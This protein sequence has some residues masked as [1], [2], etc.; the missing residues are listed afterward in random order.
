MWLRQGATDP[1]GIWEACCKK[2]AKK[3]KKI[4]FFCTSWTGKQANIH[5]MLPPPCFTV[6]M[7]RSERWAVFC[8]NEH[9]V[10][11]TKHLNFDQLEKRCSVRTRPLGCFPIPMKYVLNSKLI[12][13]PCYNNRNCGQVCWLLQMKSTTKEEKT[14]TNFSK[15]NIFNYDQCPSPVFLFLKHKVHVVPHYTITGLI[16]EYWVSLITKTVCCQ[17]LADNIGHVCYTRPH[18]E[19]TQYANVLNH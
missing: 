13:F 7:V 15:I 19:F 12:S 2:N 4:C 3:H 6:E 11:R 9:F 1:P 17:I 18:Q 5:M 16:I 10:P 14:I 8:Q